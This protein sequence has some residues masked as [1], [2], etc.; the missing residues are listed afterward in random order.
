VDACGHW[1]ET[2]RPRLISAS[3]GATVTSAAADI[4]WDAGSRVAFVRYKLAARLAVGDGVLLVDALTGWIGT[5]STPF[6][7]IADAKELRGTDGSCRAHVSTF[8]RRHRET[9]LVALFNMG[10][11]IQV[12]V[13]MFRV[14]TG[15][16]LETFGDEARARAWLRTKAIAA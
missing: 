8:F 11:V 16:Q 2:R 13:E 1:S 3:N 10:P 12:V 14:G 6:A 9:A 15:I 4:T 7:V 5:E